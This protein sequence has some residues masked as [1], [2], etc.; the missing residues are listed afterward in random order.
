[1]LAAPKSVTSKLQ[2]ELQVAGAVRIAGAR[3]SR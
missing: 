3:R 2:I 1:L